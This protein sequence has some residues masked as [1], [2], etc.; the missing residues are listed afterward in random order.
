MATVPGDITEV[1]RDLLRRLAETRAENAGVVSIYLDLDPSR[2]GTGRARATEI[3]SVIDEAARQARE[4]G[5]DLPHDAQRA[6]RGD[7][8]R[9]GDH[10]RGLDLSDTRGL[11]VFACEPAGLFETVRLRRPIETEVVIN[12]SPHVDPLARLWDGGR[13]CVLLANRRWARLFR[14]SAAGLN[15]VGRIYDEVPTRHDQGGW[16]QARYQRSIDKEASDHLKRSAEITHRRF[17]S[18]PFDNLLLGAPEES[19]AI[20]ED[21]LHSD[22]RQ[23]LRG[24][25]QVDVENAG[26]G[27]VHAAARPLIEDYERRVHDGLLARLQEGLGRGERAAAGLDD[28]LAALV[29]QRVEAL[30]LDEGFS[31]P[32]AE[33]P[34]CG[35]LGA[36]PAPPSCP[37]DGAELERRENI[38]EPMSQ[39]ALLQ[40]AVVVAL[41]ERPEL[42]A[43]GGVA[44]VLRF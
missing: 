40:D 43:H 10:L 7:I 33:C 34:H 30:L 37:V 28:V 24:R 12:S 20:L 8:A 16:S 13:W 6:L 2:F 25:V 1:D 21:A 27:D 36:D 31:S 9:L 11:A 38:A 19:Y 41:R 22:L 44:A 18:W 14:G 42:A 15:E 17:A 3:A 26:T 23:R 39:R 32:G 35:W 5:D 4:G 29:E